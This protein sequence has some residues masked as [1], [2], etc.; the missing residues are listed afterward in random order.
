[1]IA[2]IKQGN[3]LAFQNV[4][5]ELNRKVFGYFLRKTN[6][7]EDAQDLVQQTF[8]RLWK[9]RSSLNEHYSIEQQ[10]FYISR[11]VFIDYLRKQNTSPSAST[12]TSQP[13]KVCYIT[14]EFDVK[15][16]INDTLNRM[17]EIRKKAFELNRI[18]GFSYSEIASFL[19]IS[20]KS[21]D[22]HVNKAVRQLKKALMMQVLIISLSNL[23]F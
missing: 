1:M 5:L 12:T 21:V 17:P 23:F 15:R 9:Y 14:E 7:T 22:N 18:H 20:V 4:F 8:L 2:A 10:V 3:E 11:T 16:Q 13:G 19:S 6:S